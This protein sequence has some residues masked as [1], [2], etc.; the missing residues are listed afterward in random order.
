MVE[1][2]RIKSIFINFFKTLKM[3]VFMMTFILLFMKIFGA[4]NTLIGV[5]VYV[6]LAMFPYCDTGMNKS[7][8]MFTIF[9]SYV[10]SAIIS[11]VNTV[12]PLIAFPI[13]F[14]FVYF[15]TLLTSEPHYLK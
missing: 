11:Q 12:S 14:I 5:C 13:N 15:V 6:G 9:I 1:K 3:F 2:N 10:G 8:M 7:T 4:D